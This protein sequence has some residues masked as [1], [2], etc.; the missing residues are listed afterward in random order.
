VKPLKVAHLSLAFSLLLMLALLAM[1]ATMWLRLNSTAEHIRNEEEIAAAREVR[2]AVQALEDNLRATVEQLARWEETR[3]QFEHPEYYALWR[4]MRVRDVGMLPATVSAVALYDIRGHI[5][6]EPRGTSMP[7]GLGAPVARLRFTRQD[8][9]PGELLVLFPVHADMEQTRVAGYGALRLELA[10][11]LRLVRAYRYADLRDSHPHLRPGVHD[12]LADAIAELPYSV[13]PNR[14]LD[15]LNDAFQVSLLR[16]FAA[17]LVIL[18][19]GAWFLNQVLVRPLNRLSRDIDRLRAAPSDVRGSALADTSTNVAELDN[20]QRSFGEYHDK[21]AVLRQDLEKTSRDFFDQARRDALTGVYNRRAFDEDW[22][23]LADAGYLGRCALILYDCDHFKAIND[24]YGHGV[25]DLVIQA[26]ARSL[27]T[28]L[29]TGD[30]LYR[31]GG[32]EFATMLPNSDPASAEA[33]AER[34]LLHVRSHDFQQ[35]GLNEPVSVSIGLALSEPAAFN[36]HELHAR[37]DL[38][39][40]NA[41][42]PGNRKIILHS[43]A[44][45]D[46]RSLVSNRRINA[47][48]NA[49][50]RPECLLLRYPRIVRLPSRDLAY[51]EAQVRIRHGDELLAPETVLPV[52]RSHR[53]EVEFDLA[54]LRAIEEDIRIG[55]RPDAPGLY[56]N[57]SALGLL[58][59]R[60]LQAL[61]GMRVRA[62]DIEL[63]VGI[64]E[65]ALIQ[66]YDPARLHMQRLRDTGCLVALDDFGSA[67]S[68]VRHLASLPVDMI[69]FDGALIAQLAS[70]VPKERLMVGE[71]ANLVSGNGYRIVAKGVDSEEIMQRVEALGFD[72]AQ[73]S[74]LD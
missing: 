7:A 46:M 33:V 26:I 36:L 18:M 20:L 57:I 66:H 30:R 31:L 39:M 1:G 16:L 38:A 45:D 43:D 60:V 63:V 34:C 52:V 10:S 50:Q 32:D 12:R 28:A 59:E 17:L 2:E 55:R 11:Q 74:H 44:I 3:R 14:E 23:A 47:V 51:N 58:D 69:K 40:Y 25:G 27:G 67:Y 41:K 65:A 8:S 64:E 42:R 62:P 19:L 15:R 73:G 5:L 54:L 49:V 61:A 72:Y 22:H 13:V 29:R 53:L 35:Y 68:S 4:D 21:L 48:Y 24:T 71:F 70:D 9:E 56:L 37:A 6:A